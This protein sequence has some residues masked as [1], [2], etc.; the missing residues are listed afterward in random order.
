[1]LTEMGQT[2]RGAFQSLAS[3]G[4]GAKNDALRALASLIAQSHPAILAANSADV[5]EGRSSGMSAA[6]IDRLMLNDKRI[7]GLA[8]DLRHLAE[9]PD[10][11]GEH[12][13]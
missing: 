8:V 2:A 13:D 1:M 9:L 7:D 6:L 3:A 4:T 11:I 5:A 12:Y 10:P